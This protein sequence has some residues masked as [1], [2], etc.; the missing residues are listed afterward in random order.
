MAAR[1]VAIAIGKQEVGA[2]VEVHQPN[3]VV[4]LSTAPPRADA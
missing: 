4:R 2:T 1:A 3:L